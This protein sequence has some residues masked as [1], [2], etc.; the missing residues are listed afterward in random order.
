MIVAITLS[1]LAFILG[2]SAAALHDLYLEVEERADE[3]TKMDHYLVLVTN[4]HMRWFDS[5]LPGYEY[6]PM[7]TADDDPDVYGNQFRLSINFKLL[8]QKIKIAVADYFFYYDKAYRNRRDFIWQEYEDKQE[9]SYSE[10]LA[11]KITKVILKRALKKRSL[12]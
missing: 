7:G 11:K 5:C 10:Q 2:M 8:N 3:L 1:V 12:V 9:L 6:E 4:Q